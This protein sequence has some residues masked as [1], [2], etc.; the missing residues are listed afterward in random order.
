MIRIKLEEL[1]VRLKEE[2]SKAEISASELKKT[3]NEASHGMA[4]SYSVAGDVEHAK[5]TALLSLQKLEQLKKLNKEVTEALEKAMPVTAS[6]A[7]FLSIKF[8]DG[9]TS[10]L[11]Y[12]KN[13]AY[14]FGLNLISPDSIFGKA[15]LG[16]SIGS[17]FSYSA[18]DKKYSGIILSI[19]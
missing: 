16:K 19:A 4:A 8:D 7:C 5:N 2:L 13:S 14:I 11:Y 12:V 3:A 15:I 9:R 1:G 18:G 10:D 6:P 17:N